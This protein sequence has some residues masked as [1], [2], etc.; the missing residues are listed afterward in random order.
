MGRTK[1]CD[2]FDDVL[3]ISTHSPRVG[4]TS[5]GVKRFLKK[6]YFNS[7]APCGANQNCLHFRNAPSHFNSLAPCGA[8]PAGT[9][10]N[11][12]ARG[13]QLTRPVWG[14][15]V[16]LSYSFLNVGF[17]LTRP[18]WGE[19]FMN[20]V[21]CSGINISTHSPRVGR[22]LSKNRSRASH[23]YFNSL[24][25]C[26]ANPCLTLTI[27]PM[28]VI[29]T[30]SP[31]VGRTI[32]SDRTGLNSFGFQLTRPVWGEPTITL[33][34]ITRMTFQLTRPVWGEPRR[35]RDDHGIIEHFNS[36]AP[37]GANLSFGTA[38]SE[39]EYFNS[40]APC[41]ANPDL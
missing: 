31:R 25:P 24:A 34:L 35:K 22:T 9:D 4:R 13:F 20:F 17:Q 21:K 29:S 23:T 18:V 28:L 30:H 5:W 41:G 26:G 10:L 12:P 8:N 7:L 37:C 15:P 3:N 39:G 27:P 38:I 33:F 2:W 14:E 19:P 11:V 32:I 16:L 6:F 1:I 36:L 40:L